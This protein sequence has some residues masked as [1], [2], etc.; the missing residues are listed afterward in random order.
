MTYQTI[1][2]VAPVIKDAA[3]NFHGMQVV[4]FCWDRH[5]MFYAPVAKLLPP[6]MSFQ[7]VI[8]KELTDTYSRHPDFARIDWAAVQWSKDGE[9]FTPARDK[10]LL[11]NGI[12]H[13]TAVHFITP[14]LDGLNGA[15]F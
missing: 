13:K 10:S 7:E 15:G 5:L 14:G 4:Y 1:R 8:D 6:S 11:D 2:P 3:A 12:T 9:A